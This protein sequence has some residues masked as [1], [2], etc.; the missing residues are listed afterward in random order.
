MATSNVI[1]VLLSTTAVTPRGVIGCGVQGDD[2]VTVLSVT[3][4]SA[5]Y[6]NLNEGEILRVHAEAISGAG[7]FFSSGFLQLDDTKLSFTV[8]RELSRGG[9]I[10]VMNFVFSAINGDDV[11]TKARFSP[12][13]RLCFEDSADIYSSQYTGAM[14]AAL[15]KLE[16]YNS[17]LEEIPEGKTIQGQFDSQKASID[18][19]NYNAFDQATNPNSLATKISSNTA[20]ISVIQ[21]ELGEIPDDKTVQGQ[22]DELS[23]GKVGQKYNGGTGEIFNNYANNVASGSYSHAE[24]NCTTT[25]GVNSH[26]EGKSTNKATTVIT[27]VSSS[28]TNDNITTAWGTSSFSLA[29][30]NASSVSGLDCLALR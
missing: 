14:A 23:N 4:D 30:G 11:Q 17:Y 22:I 18:E 29:K 8:P 12:A 3:C 25:I 9:G 15:Q 10:A 5:L 1:N 7:E 13:V 27:E 2:N 28:T 16:K 26:A 19:I 21:D 20:K 24:G 6:P